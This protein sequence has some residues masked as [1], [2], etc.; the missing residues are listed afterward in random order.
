MGSYGNL[1]NSLADF[2]AS[3]LNLLIKIQTLAI[4]K[5]IAI[6]ERHRELVKYLYKDGESIK[7]QMYLFRTPYL[8]KFVEGTPG[9]AA[10]GGK[11]VATPTPYRQRW[12]EWVKYVDDLINALTSS[13]FFAIASGDIIKAFGYENLYSMPFFE[14]TYTV[15]PVF[16]PE[17]LL[18]IHNL[19]VCGD[20]YN[21]TAF[22]ITQDPS[23]NTLICHPYT[24]TGALPGACSVYPIIDVPIDNPSPDMVMVATRLTVAGYTAYISE[25][26][27]FKFNPSMI[28][29]EMVI[30]LTIYYFDYNDRSVAYV[31]T[32]TN[33]ID[34]LAQFGSF[35][36]Y[37]MFFD[38]HPHVHYMSVNSGKTNGAYH[39]IV[40]ELQNYTVMSPGDLEKMHEMA[41][42]GAL[43]MH[44]VDN[45]GTK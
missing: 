14:E 6:C 23:T 7:S 18:E 42:Y 33:V 4:P 27:K 5:G 11:L 29:T 22:D 10:T 32:D 16:N 34:T 25:D 13:Q 43:T 24:T 15:V 20:R 2:R 44:G 17:I 21:E 41:V 31:D 12:I 38:W 3:I 40:S 36:M 1:Y 39:S 45:V 8:Y 26:S 28:G 9:T 30:R 35:A 19:T 37:E